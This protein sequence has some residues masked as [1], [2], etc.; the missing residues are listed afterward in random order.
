[1]TFQMA[2]AFIPDLQ[3]TQSIKEISLWEGEVDNLMWAPYRFSTDSIG[4]P[5]SPCLTATTNREKMK[6]VDIIH[7]TTILLSN[8]I[9]HQISAEALWVIYRRLLTWHEDLPGNIASIDGE[10]IEMLP[11][12]LSLQ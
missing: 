1:M 7:D 4:G 5:T 2:P 12:V 3:P 10:E 9:G 11:H 6:L 8:T